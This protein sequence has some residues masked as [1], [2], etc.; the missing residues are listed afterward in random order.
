[1]RDRD[2]FLLSGLILASAGMASFGP[3]YIKAS[4]LPPLNCSEVNPAGKEFGVIAVYGAGTTT[5][6]EGTEI[7][8]E[9]QRYRLM[10]A[11]AAYASGYSNHILLLDAGKTEA[12][13]T[14]YEIIRSHVQTLS[15]GSMSFSPENMTII[16][17]S[18]NTAENAIDLA[19][20][21]REH[22]ISDALSITDQFHQP[23]VGMLESNNG[24]N[25][26]VVPTECFIEMFYPGESD[27]V[28][29]R[30]QDDHMRRLLAKEK[31][32]IWEL[33]FDRKGLLTIFLKK[34]FH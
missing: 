13:S 22:G 19:K 14:S 6:A 3:Q 27:M 31:K 29:Q 18:L 32:A 7:P 28:R 17:D 16:N 12:Q 5:T 2:K 24:L 33:G 23:R 11:A 34:L 8:N 25:S 30:N 4:D 15:Q 20:F 21:M 10:A 26:N 1:M 9:F